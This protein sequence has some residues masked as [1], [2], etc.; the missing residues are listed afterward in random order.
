MSTNAIYITLPCT[1]PGTL[2]P[3]SFF[4]AKFTALPSQNIA[5]VTES[6]ASE[7]MASRKIILLE[8]ANSL[9]SS[10]ESNGPL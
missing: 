5:L 3:L 10:P 1:E 2:E 8:V 7:E 4:P 9:T 6:S